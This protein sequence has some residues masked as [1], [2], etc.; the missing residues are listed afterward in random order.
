MYNYFV[1]SQYHDIFNMQNNLIIIYTKG[2]LDLRKQHVNMQILIN[3]NKREILS[4]EK[5]MARIERKIDEKHNK[6]LQLTK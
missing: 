5:E 2:T 1:I 3:N 6:N 4:N